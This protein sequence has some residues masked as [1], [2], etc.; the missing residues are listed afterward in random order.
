MNNSGSQME[1]H[2]QAFRE[3]AA[4]L[5]VE[6]ESAVLELED[7]PDDRATLDRIFRAMHTVK[8]SGAMFG[9][10]R[11]ASFTHHIETVLDKARSGQM[12]VTRRLIDLILASRDQISAM[13]DDP[14]AGQEQR[15]EIE[16]ALSELLAS[17]GA[18]PAAVKETPK[19]AAPAYFRIRIKMPR[20]ATTR[21]VDPL[22]LLRDLK[23]LGDCETT[24]FTDELPALPAVEAEQLYFYWDVILTTS[25]GLP[26]VKDVFIFVEEDGGISIEEVK[27]EKDGKRIGDL[28]VEKK[29]VSR[30]DVEYVLAETSL[31][32]EKLV[33]SG[34]V[35]KE[36]VKAA[37]KEQAALRQGAAPAQ[38]TSIRVAAEKL[39]RLINLVGELVITRAQL[40]QSAARYTD[41]RLIAP[42]E[43]VERLTDELRECVLNVRM[44]PIGATFEKLK[45]LVRDLAAGLNKEINLVV[46]GGETE[47]DK[48]VIERI[49][50]P[51][52]HLIRNSIDHGIETPEERV[53]AGKP[54]Q[55]TLSI[56]ASHAGGCVLINVEDDGKGLDRN[57]ILTKAQTMGVI[58]KGQD[59]TDNEIFNLI[60]NPGLSTAKKVSGVSGRGVGMDV[61]KREILHLRGTIDVN[62]WSG[63]GTHVSMK[64]PL[65]LAIID[66]LL[67]EVSGIHYVIPLSHVRECVE[68][69]RRQVRAAHGRCLVRVRDELI[70][71]IRLRQA[72]CL[73]SGCPDIEQIVIVEDQNVRVGVVVDNII[74]NSQAVIKALG[75]VFGQAEGVSGATILGDGTVALIVDI[76]GLVRLA[77]AEEAAFIAGHQVAGQQAAPIPPSL[78]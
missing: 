33:A 55:G 32:G 6:L 41:S 44:L 75:R 3:E 34:T 36:K 7:Q 74:G 54:R 46:S 17:T 5:L 1:R 8:G 65:T 12:A 11:V 14:N 71:Y 56:S 63:E 38:V 19:E 21:G 24:V 2:I 13:L 29:D 60:F 61:V 59:L 48:T 10:D 64:L 70:S 78:A 45:R 58:E 22:T 69:T 67:V 20:E 66:G 18:G 37:L 26:A 47:L 50:D 40:S 35:S 9:F 73:G 4:D 43:N 16:A 62:S 39:D 57:A 52:V 76:A 51:L 68:L 27:P 23:D 28:L 15:A 25:A 72:F 42:V 77:Q 31:A 30:T 53:A 49:N